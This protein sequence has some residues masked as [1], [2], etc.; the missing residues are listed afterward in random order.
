M[1]VKNLAVFDGSKWEIA[2]GLEP[3]GVVRTVFKDVC[4]NLWIGGDFDTVGETKTGPLAVMYR[5]SNTF[6]PVGTDGANGWS[7]GAQLFDIHIDCAN[8]P[9]GGICSEKQCDIYVAG[10]FTKSVSGVDTTHAAFYKAKEDK[11]G[12]L[13][14]LAGGP[15]YAVRYFSNIETVFV[16]GEIEGYVKMT[17]RDN[18]KWEPLSTEENSFN[19]IVRTMYADP[20]HFVI[21]NNHLYI[22]GDFTKPGMKVARFHTKDNTFTTLA[23]SDTDMKGSVRAIGLSSD[24]VYIGGDFETGTTAFVAKVNEKRN[25]WENLSGAQVPIS[26]TINAMFVCT[27]SHANCKNGDVFAAGL[28]PKKGSSDYNDP[29]DYRGNAFFENKSGGDWVQFGFGVNGDIYGLNTA[30]S[31]VRSSV[32]TSSGLALLVMTLL[33]FIIAFTI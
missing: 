15:A 9:A 23:K 32:H 7:P 8:F 4:Q 21:K 5:G 11:W 31:G 28:N 24:D 29:T 22:G 13:Q 17:K 33:T 18:V 2:G 26:H 30:F 14:G 20:D 6:E 19:G 3:N 10:K 16:G 12:T 25:F 1:D 27:K